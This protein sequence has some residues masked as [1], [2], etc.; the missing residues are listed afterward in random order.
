MKLNCKIILVAAFVAQASLSLT[1]MGQEA[2]EEFDPNKVV[3]EIIQNTPVTYA[4]T[5]YNTP[6]PF[7]HG[8]GIQGSTEYHNIN[9]PST[10]EYYNFFGNA[11]DVVTIEVHR[12]TNDMDPGLMLCFGT[13]DDSEGIFPFFG[14]LCGPQMG[15][16]VGSADDNN[17]VPHGVGGYNADPRIQVILPI[18]GEYTLMV[19]DFFGQGPN[20]EFEIH[21]DGIID[22]N[23][24]R[25]DDG[26]L[27][28]DDNCPDTFNPDQVDSDGDGVGDVCDQ[29]EGSDDSV[30]SDADGVPDGCDLCP[31][32][33][34][35]LDSDG[36][37]WSDYCDNCPETA[38][39]EQT[40]SDG[41]GVG[42]ACE[43]CEGSSFESGDLSN[44]AS[45]GSTGVVTSAIGVAPTEGTYQAFLTT[46]GNAASVGAIESFLSLAPGALHNLLVSQGGG[47][48]TDPT[49]G[50]AIRTS[51]TLNAGDTISFDWN[52]LSGEGTTAFWNDFSFVTITCGGVTLLADTFHPTFIGGPSG[53][54]LQTGYNHFAFTCP[55]GGLI[56]IGF[57]V[58]DTLD[59]TVDSGL[60]IDNL[61][62]PSAGDTEPTNTAPTCTVDFTDAEA[63]FLSPSTGVFVVTEGETI[64]VDFIGSDADG[65]ILTAS[66]S[67]LPGAIILPSSGPQ[68]L[69]SVVSWTPTAADKAGAPYTVLVTFE[70]PS[71]ASTTCE[72]TIEDIN[73]N[74][75]CNAGADVNFECDAPDGAMIT[76]SATASDADDATLAYHWSVSDMDVLLD[77]ANIQSPTGV[78]P[79]GITMATL[80]V[81]DGRGGVCV[82]DVVITVADT[83]PPEVMITTDCAALWPPKHNM[84][85][86]TLIIFATDVCENPENVIP[87]LV[88]VSSNEPDNISGNGD[89]NTI[90]D[91]G[92]Q[93]GHAGYVDVTSSFTYD[94]DLGAWVGTIQ[95]RAERDG[96]GDGRAYTI[97]VSAWD[98]A[99]NIA[100]TSC[101]VVVPHDKRG[102][103]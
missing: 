15:P 56:E 32:E 18:T 103:N 36:D 85:E 3:P 29:C 90:G 96:A 14:G 59:M 9:Q 41:D 94:Y 93:D 12:T 16:S 51:I 84:R 69:P 4:G 46:G 67:G 81:T 66:V 77:D 2:Q 1:T 95:L 35:N 60:L 26:V 87:L 61:C 44:F 43:P 74:P 55:V 50:S 47:G 22:P 89:G 40:D 73:L 24:D 42:D 68:P 98:S 10:W 64:T 49:E 92:G 25:D 97:D 7:A 19:F 39:A 13:T 75:V 99:N 28:V 5:L 37:G 71:G 76:L 83:T 52:F 88:T 54:G 58:L 70:D 101:V 86:V 6:V 20:P 100:T 38:N 45:I 63:N 30:D 62:F 102:G 78:F 11:G 79:V 27:N 23:P 31:G 21:V 17:G 33:D 57:G 65:D 34:D 91:V 53:F 72:F 80:T 48:S 82:D 8:T